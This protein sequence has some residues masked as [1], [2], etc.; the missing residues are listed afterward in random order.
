MRIKNKLFSNKLVIKLAILL[1]LF[2]FQNSLGD[3]I[4][5][6]VEFTLPLN[7]LNDP[8][9]PFTPLVRFNNTTYM[10]Y[11]DTTFRP[12][13]IQNNSN[14]LIKVPLDSNP[15]YTAFPDGHHRFSMGIDENGYLHI[16]GD[17][18]FYPG[19][20]GNYLPARYVNQTI[21]YWVSNAPY[22][23]TQGFTF[24]G[25]SNASTAIPGQG[26]VTGRF[27]NDKSNRLYY[28]TMCQAYYAYNANLKAQLG[29]GLFSYNS[30]TKTWTAIGNNTPPYKGSEDPT[31]IQYF[32]IFYWEY[33]G[34]NGSFQNYQP[35]FTFDNNDVL[36]FTVAGIMDFSPALVTR[37]FYAKSPDYGKTWYKANGKLIPGLPLRGVDSEPNCADVVFDNK[38]VG[39]SIGVTTFVVADAQSN[40]M[41]ST[42]L[43]WY[44]NTWYRWNGK[45]WT[46]DV[47][48]PQQV[49]GSP[50][51]L[52]P[53]GKIN[54]IQYAVLRR[55]KTFDTSSIAYTLSDYAQINDFSGLICMS[56]IGL[57]TSGA[58]YG[59][60][61]TPSLMK[62][63]RF[64]ID[65]KNLPY[66]WN[67]KN[68]GNFRLGGNVDYDNGQ[69][70]LNTQGLGFQGLTDSVFYVFRSLTGDATITAQIKQQNPVNGLTT[71]G[72]MIRETL[73]PNSRFAYIGLNIAKQLTFKTRSKVGGQTDENITYNVQLP[74]WLKLVKTSNIF[75]AYY[76]VDNINW[77]Q[78]GQPIT[79]NLAS[80]YFI[81]LASSSY[82]D[83]RSHGS[84]I[85]NVRISTPTQFIP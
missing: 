69:F 7:G 40:P 35:G 75:T 43:V 17:M 79:I 81:G 14:G 70:L 23:V 71:D 19:L 41:V 5:P 59:I 33:A 66:N 55:A 67:T 44:Q 42:N 74:V 11:V 32:K 48:S 78:A 28:S 10:V 45:Q 72:L 3:I 56:E 52:G 8:S 1:N 24:R 16:T 31:Y 73:D 22:D 4:T 83:Y 54:L 39:G 49:I 62:I 2:S 60:V 57:K 36:H 76:S 34:L 29:V 51:L 84:I 37:L 47:T 18:H 13:V 15:D 27:F 58:L 65:T 68:I 30:E 85:D 77:V 46:A 82:H 12:Y 9:D 61:T 6:T 25:G 80:S 21:L 26:F 64:D 38:G 20:P 63:T 53:D 50:A